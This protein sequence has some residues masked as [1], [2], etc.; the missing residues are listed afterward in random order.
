MNEIINDNI[1]LIFTIFPYDKNSGGNSI[2]PSMIKDINKL[3]NK[4]IIYV[5][6]LNLPETEED[7]YAIMK[8]FKEP[9]LPIVT[10]DMVNDKNNI[11]IYPEAVGNPLNFNK[12]VRFNFY[13][14]VYEPNVDN[15]YNIFYI[16][17]FYNLYNKVREMYGVRTIENIK[18][19]DKFTYY[20]N[21]LNDV[22]NDCKDY[23]LEREGSCFTIRKGYTLPHI[24]D[25]FNVH[26]LNSYE[27]QHH[28]S[29]H[30][31]LVNIFN[32]YKYFYC[33]DGFSFLVNIASLCGCIPIIVPFSNFKSI[34]EF[35]DRDY[36]LYGIAYGDSEEQI[37][38]AINTK[39]KMR[40][41][42]EFYRDKNYDEDFKELINSIYNNFN[43]I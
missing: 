29:N 40:Q 32:K 17:A 31:D 42:L 34:S 37:N 13:F 11:A 26:P 12:I 25:N 7:Y 27:I 36:Y 19:Y 5:F 35:S 15:E 18:Y 28:E 8:T 38:H 21:N 39:D 1:K 20:F 23:G 14:N 6:I 9:Y 3:Y 33:Y 30:T 22:L 2:I 43:I 41:S 10:R 16:Y 24:R 4:P